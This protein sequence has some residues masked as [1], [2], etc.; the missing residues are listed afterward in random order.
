MDMLTYGAVMKRA[1]GSS[2][3]SQRSPTLAMSLVDLLSPRHELFM[4]HL[5][6]FVFSLCY[7]HKDLSI[8][9]HE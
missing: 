3:L 1:D 7:F 8:K 5:A 6:R 4:F 2:L 9:T